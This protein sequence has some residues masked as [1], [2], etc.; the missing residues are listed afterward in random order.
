[1]NASY[2]RAAK[3]TFGALRQDADYLDKL[4]ADALEGL[5]KG[6]SR[7]S[8]AGYLELAP[9]IRMRVLLK[10]FAGTCDTARLERLD[11]LL[12]A[13]TGAEQL[14]ENLRLVAGERE[15]RVETGASPEKKTASCAYGL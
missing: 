3:R 6:N 2:L 9:P 14:A 5:C 15:F 7:Y 10:L 8:R 4:A 12:N 13:G 11:S 1:V